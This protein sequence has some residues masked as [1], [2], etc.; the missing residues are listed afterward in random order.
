MLINERLDE[1]V[2]IVGEKGSV[3]LM[4]LCQK[5]LASESTI[6][7][8]LSY[9]HN[10]KKLI[11]V[12]GGAKKLEGNLITKDIEISSRKSEHISQKT[13]IAKYCASLI[14]KN[15]YVYIDSGSSTEML[16]KHINIKGVCFVTNSV[17]IA[18]ILTR[19]GLDTYI[20]GGKIKKSTESI[21]GT[22]ALIELDKFNFSKGFF[23]ANGISIDGLTTPDNE[24]A[25]IKKRAMSRCDLK[26]VLADSSKFDKL[27]LV[28]FSEFNNCKIV[29]EKV[30]NK[31][32]D[33]DSVI[34]LEH[35]S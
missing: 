6:R 20:V 26:Y 32:K 15:D 11:K 17:S 33:F 14:E 31:Y 2:K 24:E 25:D 22:N 34:N 12:R 29:T 16:A 8:D 18:L 23:G 21:I 13:K 19:K 7:R 10:Q 28:K 5:L 3:D 35:L 30:S 9:L 27:S 4:Y 1:I